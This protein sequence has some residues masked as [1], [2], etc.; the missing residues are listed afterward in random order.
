MQVWIWRVY[1]A[2]KKGR[3]YD[4]NF[5]FTLVKNI[6]LFFTFKFKNTKFRS[7]LVWKTYNIKKKMTDIRRNE[8]Y[9]LPL[10]LLSRGCFYFP[11]FPVNKKR[12]F[13]TYFTGMRKS[14]IHACLE[15]SNISQLKLEQKWTSSFFKG[16]HYLSFYLFQY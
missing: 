7:L 9:I 4:S 2:C 5:L 6:E 13:H 12:R 8:F 16:R 3:N 10:F 11:Y 15:K 14:R 1:H